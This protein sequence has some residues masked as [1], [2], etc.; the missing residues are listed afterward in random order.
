M[1]KFIGRDRPALPGQSVAEI[2]P[3]TAN[4]GFLVIAQAAETGIPIRNRRVPLARARARRASVLLSVDLLEALPGARQ[5]RSGPAG[6]A[7]RSRSAAQ[8][9][10]RAAD[11]GPAGRHQPRHRR[12]GARSEESR[13]TPSC[14]TWKWRG[15]AGARRHRNRAADGD[16]LARDPAPR[17]RGENVPR[18]HPAGGV[19][20]GPAFRCR[21][22]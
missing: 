7:A 19:E 22:W 21:S 11:R 5:S 3:P 9:R 15:Q 20:A 12:R 13:S 6:A 17:P 1:E 4:L 2:F 10:P 16:H 18:F 14:C 8:D